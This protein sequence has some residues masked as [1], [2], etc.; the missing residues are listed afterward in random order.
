MTATDPTL[1]GVKPAWPGRNGELA[2]GAVAVDSPLVIPLAR[3]RGVT[4]VSQGCAHW[5]FHLDVLGCDQA[6]EQK[7][8]CHGCIRNGLTTGETYFVPPWRCRPARAKVR[9]QRLLCRF[10]GERHDLDPRFHR[11]WRMEQELFTWLCEQVLKQPL[12]QLERLSGVP[13]KRL[14][15]LRAPLLRQMGKSAGEWLLP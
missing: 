10:G 6:R 12:A 5:L 15:A 14:T 8:L 13:A 11:G 1:T 3:H 7:G 4:W 9:I 2:R